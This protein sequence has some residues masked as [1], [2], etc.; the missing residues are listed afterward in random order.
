MKTKEEWD[1]SGLPLDYYMPEPC[2]IDEEMYMYIAKWV[3][4]HYLEDGLIQCG[5]PIR[6][7]YGELMEEI[8]IRATV[9][10]VNGKYFYLGELPDFK[11]H[12]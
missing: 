10:E 7:T 4:P 3:C 12:D 1:T 9:S 2:E 11:Q 6:A 8:M 5:E